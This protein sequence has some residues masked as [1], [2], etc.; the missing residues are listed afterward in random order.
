LLAAQDP[1]LVPWV[2]L[3]QFAGPPEPVLQQCRAIIDGR[4]QPDERENLLAVTQ[5]LARL[6]YNDEAL[7][8][9]FG[10][11]QAMLELPYMHEIVQELVAERMHRG[12]LGVLEARFGAV[13][14]EVATA[15]KATTDDEQFQTL[16]KLAAQCPD[17]ATFRAQSS[18]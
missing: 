15:V 7:M 18:P 10:G 16:L 9:I 3:T 12:I 8:A 11:R 17:L 4:A 5:V 1:G 2:P 13:P 6:R 14:E